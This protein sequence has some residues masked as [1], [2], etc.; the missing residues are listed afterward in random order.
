M[1]DEGEQG[2]RKLFIKRRSWKNIIKLD[3]L[4]FALPLKNILAE[5]FLVLRIHIR[6]MFMI[7]HNRV[8]FKGL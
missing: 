8:N 2:A 1:W 5:Y 7:S 6:K 4:F 3:G